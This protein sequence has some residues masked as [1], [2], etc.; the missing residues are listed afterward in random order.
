MGYMYGYINGAS[1]WDLVK[2]VC[3]GMLTGGVVGALCGLG[4]VGIIAA[5]THITSSLLLATTAVTAC[6]YVTAGLVG[7]IMVTG[8]C[9]LDLYLTNLLGGLWAPKAPT[10]TNQ[11]QT[12]PE[13][14]PK[15]KTAASFIEF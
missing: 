4:G 10:Q 1:G 12:T 7:T 14:K 8:G 5:A 2:Y 3:V 6:I 15:P 9:F 11:T 13:T